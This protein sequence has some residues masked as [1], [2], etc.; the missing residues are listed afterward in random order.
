MGGGGKDLKPILKKKK[1]VI[2]N[3]KLCK[4]TFVQVKNE[5]MELEINIVGVT[6]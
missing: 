1:K 4:T 5:I 6:M 3:S 2:W